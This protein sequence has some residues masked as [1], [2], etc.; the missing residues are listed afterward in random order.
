M[1]TWR[2]SSLLAILL[3]SPVSVLA[4]PPA[5]PGRLPTSTP[6][7][8]A[9]WRRFSNQ[10]IAK[11][12]GQCEEKTHVKTKSNGSKSST[13]SGSRRAWARYG[14]D[15]VL[16]FNVTTPTDAIAIAEA[17]RD[18]YLDVWEFNDDWVDIRL[19]KNDACSPFARAQ[20]I[21][22]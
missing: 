1:R 16:R 10:V 22:Y 21:V 6:Q 3:L 2:V 9:T 13:D 18:L 20:H 7:P 11:L 12:W 8:Q 14:Q 17:S 5:P 15:I 19:A 4:V